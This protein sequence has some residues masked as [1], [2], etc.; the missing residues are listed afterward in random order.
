MK[1]KKIIPLEEVLYKFKRHNDDF[2]N[3]LDKEEQMENMGSVKNIQKDIKNDIIGMKYST[4]LK[5]AS[6]INEIKSGLGEEVKKNPNK[7]TKVE[8]K[9]TEKLSIYIKKLFT[10]F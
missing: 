4:D 1:D 7:I 9:W 3:N 2:M 5:K 10:K 8:K 6:F